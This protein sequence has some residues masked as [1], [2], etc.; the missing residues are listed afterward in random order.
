MTPPHALGETLLYQLLH[1]RLVLDELAAELAADA[2][3]ADEVDAGAVLAQRQRL[4][5]RER[6]TG[7]G[8]CLGGGG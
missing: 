1:A 4:R 6:R 2:V 8:V 3:D 7:G 5:G